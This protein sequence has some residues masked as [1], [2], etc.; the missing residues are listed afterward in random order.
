[1]VDQ[2][3]GTIVNIASVNAFLQPD[4]GTIDYGLVIVGSELLEGFLFGAP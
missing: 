1:M 4:G 3:H 2:G